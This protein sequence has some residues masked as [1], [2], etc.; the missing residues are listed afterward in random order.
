MRLF[1]LQDN[2]ANTH[3]ATVMIVAEPNGAIVGDVE[4]TIELVDS[5]SA[6]ALAVEVEEVSVDKVEEVSVDKVEEVEEVEVEIDVDVFVVN[7]AAVVKAG[8]P[9]HEISS[10]PVTATSKYPPPT[11][12]MISSPATTGMTAYTSLGLTIV[13]RSSKL[14]QSALNGSVSV[15]AVGVVLEGHEPR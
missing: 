13:Q 8:V 11:R 3:V 2:C 15:V 10:V 9:V 12:M 6:G 1:L 4:T 7:D 14:A 5:D